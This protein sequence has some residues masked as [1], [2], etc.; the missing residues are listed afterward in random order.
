MVSLYVIAFAAAG[1]F[2]TKIGSE[3][4]DEVLVTSPTCGMVDESKTGSIDLSY[5][6]LFP[7]YA[8]DLASAASYTQRCYSNASSSSDCNSFDKTKLISTIDRNASCPFHGSICRHQDRNI[9]LDTGY[10][11]SHN[12]LGINTPP[13]HRIALRLVHH[14]APLVTD[15]HK[16][17][18]NYSDDI[19][20]ARYYYGN[21][22]I[23]SQYVD[24]EFTYEHEQINTLQMVSEEKDYGSVDYSPK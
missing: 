20:Y 23:R 1:V 5:T 8:R 21:Q 3:S 22:T 9:K 6:I 12:D 7:F 19:S 15:G 4:G 17:F 10:I 11:D 14:C 24:L 16:R 13:D 18:Y 2:S